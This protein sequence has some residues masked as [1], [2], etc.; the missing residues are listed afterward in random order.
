MAL[1]FDSLVVSIL[2]IADSQD[3]DP[4]AFIVEADSPVTDSERRMDSV[5]SFDVSCSGGSQAA[6]RSDDPRGHGAIQ[7]GQIGLR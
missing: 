4:V 2:A 3:L 5:E 7:G 6:N 1:R